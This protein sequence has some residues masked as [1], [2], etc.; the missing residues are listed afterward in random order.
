MGDGQL[1]GIF[2]HHLA[3]PLFS[4]FVLNKKTILSEEGLLR[5]LTKKEM[6]PVLEPYS[7][8]VDV[9]TFLLSM[10][11][12]LRSFGFKIWLQQY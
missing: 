9:N 3:E 12:L 8:V 10:E 4:W 5:P 2:G 11:A 7:V 1:K 6:S